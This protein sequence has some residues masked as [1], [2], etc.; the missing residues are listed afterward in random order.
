MTGPARLPR[1]LLTFRVPRS[2]AN[3][4]LSLFVEN[5]TPGARLRYFSWPGALF[6]RYDLVH[7]H[8]PEDIV[9]GKS[10]AQTA[11]FL[12]LG[13]VWVA[14]LRLQR[15]PVIWTVHNLNPHESKNAF[16]RSFVAS[17]SRVVGLKIMLNESDENDPNA[18]TILHGD[19]SRWLAGQSY[20][21]QPANNRMLYFGLLRPYKGVEDLITAF[22]GAR[23][24]GWTLIAAGRPNDLDY[25]ASL[26]S[27]A[28]ATAGVSLDARFLPDEDLVRYLTGSRLV[29]LPY[30][31]MYNSGSALL[32]LSASKP[33]LVPRTASTSWLREEVGG[34]WVTLF[35]APL[36]AGA[37]LEALAAIPA[38]GSVPALGRRNWSSI[39]VLH[40]DL[41][42]SIVTAARRDRGSWAAR[43]RADI[44]RSPAFVEHSL[45][46]RLPTR[47]T[48]PTSR[49]LGGTAARGGFM[50]LIGQVAR[51]SIQFTGIVVLA[52]LLL[53]ADFGLLAMVVAIVGIGEVFRDFGLSTAAVQARSLSKEQKDNLFWVN[54][55]IGAALALIVYSSAPLIVMLYDEIRLYELIHLLSF[56]FLFNGLTTQFRAQLNRDM[57]FGRLAIVDIASAALGLIVAIGLAL[58]GAGYWVLGAQ[59]VVVALSGLVAGALLAGWWPGGL[60]RGVGTAVF[61]KFGANLMGVQLLTYASKNIDS[62]IIGTQLGAAQLGLYDRA[63]QVLVLPLNQINAPA[64]KVALPILSQLHDDRVRFDEFLLRG[65]TIMIHVLCAI[66]AFAA[67]QAPLLIPL[68]LGPQW[69]QSAPIFQILAVGGAAQAVS[70]ATY[71]VFLS[72]GLTGSNL[73]FAALSR[74][75][76]I[77]AIAV[78]SIWGV[79]GVAAGYSVGL[80][81]LWPFGLWWIGRA[82]NAPALRMLLNGL[83][84]ISAYGIAGCV[85]FTASWLSAG[86][87]LGL[88]FGFVAFVVSIGLLSVL[89]PKYR[90]ELGAIAQ[91]VRLLRR[92]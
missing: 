68:V 29:I 34:N 16:E 88:A 74:P 65:Q 23:L 9:R 18:V 3:P 78:G 83:R 89:W 46:N 48:V 55:G 40:S 80:L 24:E 58:A 25:A 2:T 37:I 66:F 54:S 27:L 41:Y 77:A 92:P 56:T 5:V 72:K 70:Y 81:L 61:L 60:H 57:R 71:W 90:A 10:K 63:F 21:L 14:L 43:A 91:T 28:R 17:I 22:A 51:V 26:E 73:R 62:V 33:I 47:K 32:A 30:K 44:A 1:V 49:G 20:A 8:W 4:F 85:S 67:A 38:S 76:L 6:A 45:R 11:L 31:H 13:A 15:K 75:I 82:S 64:T 84:A 42:K 86:N 19:Y 12:L 39:G 79:L 7:I 50:T 87:L 69:T 36:S 53:P 35:D 52:R 59:Q